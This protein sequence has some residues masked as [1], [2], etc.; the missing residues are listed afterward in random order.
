MFVSSMRYS[1]FIACIAVGLK[2]SVIV[3]A[4]NIQ[5][6][7]GKEKTSITK[8]PEEY[9]SGTTAVLCCKAASSRPCF[10]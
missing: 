5:V 3:L 4:D 8:M 2:H 6:V 7:D 1:Y 9:C 10:L